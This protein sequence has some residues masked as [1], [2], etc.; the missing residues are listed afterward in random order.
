MTRWQ[1]IEKKARAMRRV[2]KACIVVKK[3]TV[4]GFDTP[5]INGMGKCSGCYNPDDEQLEMQCTACPHNEYFIE[6]QW[7]NE[8]VFEDEHIW[9]NQF[10]GENN[11][12]TLEIYH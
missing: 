4:S 1:Q 8:R 10:V 9:Q 6:G 3:Y 7:G 2:M 12:K 11:N 5:V